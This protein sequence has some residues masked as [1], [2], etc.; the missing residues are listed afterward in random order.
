MLV[1]APPWHSAMSMPV[2]RSYFAAGQI[3]RDVYVAGGMVGAS[4]Q[5]VLRLDRFDP[6]ADTWMREPDLPGQARAAAGAALDGKLYV[7]GGQT[8]G[9]TSRRVYAYDVRTRRWSTAAPLPSARYNAAAATL[10]GTVYVVGGVRSIDPTRSAYAYDPRANRWHTIA[11][12]PRA[13]HTL[14][15]V[16]YHH[17][18][19]AI[20]GFDTAGNA[21]RSVYVYSPRTGRWRDGPR[22][23]APVAMLGA[24]TSADRVFAVSE[25]VFETYTPHSG[26]RLGPPLG[27]PRHALGLFAAAGRLWAIGGC[28]VPELADSRVVESRPLG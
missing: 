18:L 12:L 14:A 15:L 11:P 19:W 28:V 27:V 13:R 22:L 9:G 23:A 10:G 25:N 21:T 6:R 8:S 17:E 2:R 4:G 1:A 3:G 26:W 5:Y 20:G 24:A 16:P 7:L